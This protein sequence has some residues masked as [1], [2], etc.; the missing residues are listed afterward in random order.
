LLCSCEFST[1][2]TTSGT[3]CFQLHLNYQSSSFGFVYASYDLCPMINLAK[4]YDFLRL[5]LPTQPTTSTSILN[6]TT[7]QALWQKTLKPT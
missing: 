6:F 1:F 7:L 5:T 3:K 2:F 4:S